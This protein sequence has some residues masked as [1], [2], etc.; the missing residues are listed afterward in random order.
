MKTLREWEVLRLAFVVKARISLT[1]WIFVP[2]TSHMLISYC[3]I[4]K[5][6]TI[7]DVSIHT[8]CMAEVMSLPFYEYLIVSGLC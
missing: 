7:P 2:Y 4:Y 5:Y 3:D 8:V 6:L 1:Y